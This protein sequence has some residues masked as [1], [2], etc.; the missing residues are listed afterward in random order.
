MVEHG[1]GHEDGQ[2]KKPVSFA[3]RSLTDVE[4]NYAQVEKELLAIIYACKKFHFFIYSRTVEVHTDHKPLVS[5]IKS[6]RIQR[7]R[8]KL[9]IYNLDVKYV[10]GKEMH[11]ADHLSRS[12]LKDEPATEFEEYADVVHSV[13]MSDD[14]VEKFKVETEQDEVFS[15]V[16]EIY[17]AGWPNEKK[18]VHDLAKPFWKFKND[19]YCDDGLLFLGHR[20]VVPTILRTET[21]EKL[22]E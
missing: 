17:Q 8:M 22:H 1:D 21:L 2:N 5:K 3:S 16:N 18:K 13:N 12:Y 9:L 14:K 15:K 19:L 10:P 4:I 7:M 11:I 6:S 20:I